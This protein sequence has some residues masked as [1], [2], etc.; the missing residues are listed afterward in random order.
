MK[1]SIILSA[2]CVLLSFTCVAQNLQRG[3]VRTPE[4]RNPDGTYTKIE[5]LQGIQIELADRANPVI[6]RK[7]GNFDFYVN[8]SKYRIKNVK[9]GKLYF[10]MNESQVYA[11]QNFT[12]NKTLDIFMTNLEE[13]LMYQRKWERIER[14]K[15][16]K[17]TD[18]LLAKIDELKAQGQDY[19]IEL[20]ELKTRYDNEDNLIKSMVEK[21]MKWDFSD[22]DEYE[23]QFRIFTMNGEYERRD[24]LQRTRGDIIG[25]TRKLL[26][27][28]D[29]IANKKAQA[30]ELLRDIAI[31]DSLS[32]EQLNLK[33]QECYNSFIVYRDRAQLD[34]AAIYI[35]QRAAI[36]TTNVDWQFDAG[37]YLQKYVAAYSKAME[38]Y[39]RALKCEVNLHGE[40]HPD[41]ATSYNNIGVICYFQGD[42]AQAIEYYT[43]A[44]NIRLKVLGEEHPSVINVREIIDITKS[45]MNK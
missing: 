36:D 35:E 30:E 5:Y 40:E 29:A 39:Q 24:S 45:E 18:K 15:Y 2:L 13:D 31:A 11:E 34:S 12:A 16:Q 44:L 38:Y 41:V 4:R 22:V 37:K 33:A 10:L 19:Q 20:Q 9:G 42:Y 32:K 26:D 1:K 17:Q 28:R 14:E 27:E 6:S 7:D 8:G 3:C 43:K 25:D 23:R 21:Y